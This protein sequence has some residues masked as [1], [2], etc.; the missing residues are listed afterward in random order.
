MLYFKVF[1][2]IEKCFKFS[3]IV[4]VKSFNLSYLKKEILLAFTE[5]FT[6]FGYTAL[7]GTALSPTERS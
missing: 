6:I 2:L 4:L 1:F 3:D 7:S 5:V